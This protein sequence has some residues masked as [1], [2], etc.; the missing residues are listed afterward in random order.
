MK[1]TIRPNVFAFQVTNSD[2]GEGAEIVVGCF[3]GRA[4]L[5]LELTERSLVALRDEV[6]RALA[7][8]RRMNE[9]TARML[10]GGQ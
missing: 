3:E 1:V 5:T 6:D 8:V 2:S 10:G 9:E 7:S 4:S